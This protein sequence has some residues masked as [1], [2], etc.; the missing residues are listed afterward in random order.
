MNIPNNFISHETIVCD[1]KDPIK[2]IKSLIQE[3]KR[4]IQKIPQKQ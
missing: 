2:A 3:K 4:H 1:D